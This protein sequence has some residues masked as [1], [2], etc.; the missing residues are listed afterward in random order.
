[1]GRGGGGC[2]AGGVLQGRVKD[3]DAEYGVFV[4]LVVVVTV[5]CIYLTINL[6]YTQR[7]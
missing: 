4:V 6:F 2:S 1:V 7:G 3:Y 5:F